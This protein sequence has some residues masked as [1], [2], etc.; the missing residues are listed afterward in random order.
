LNKKKTAELDTLTLTTF[1]NEIGKFGR[2]PPYLKAFI[3]G[4]KSNKIL[5]IG[6]VAS[7]QFMKGEK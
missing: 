4:K 6:E 1:R 3:P 2:G 5:R 7:P